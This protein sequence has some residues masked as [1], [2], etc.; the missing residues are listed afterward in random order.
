MRPICTGLATLCF[1]L[2]CAL[3]AACGDD[4]GATPDGAP[5]PVGLTLCG[6]TCV[7]T[8]VDG[9]NCGACGTTCD[10][11]SV[12][13]GAGT[14][15]LSCQSGLT[16]CNG[17]CVDTDSDR[18]NCGACGT[19]CDPG[20]VCDG[21]GQCALS[22]QSGLI[23]CNGTCIDP[24]TDRA[25][26]GATADCQGANAGTVC[27]AGEVCETGTC[28]LSCPGGQIACNGACIDP[29][30]DRTYCGASADCAGANAGTTCEDGFVCNGAG[31]CELSCQSGLVDCNG[32]CIDP[33]TDRTY[34]GAS[35]DC[36]GANAGTT[37]DSGF[38]CN[39]AG[40]CA[41]S[42]QSGLTDCSGTCVALDT[43]ENCGA[44]GNACGPTATCVSG[45]C[46][47][48]N[49]VTFAFTGAAQTFVV[50]NGVT[51]I[52]IEAWG[53]SGGSATNN[54]SL[55][56][57]NGGK[58]GL[59]GYATGTLAVTPGE[60]LQILV[61]GAGQP[62]PAGGFNGGGVGCN[63]S[64]TC[65]T[66][67]GASDVRRGG[68]TLA[69]RVLVAGGGGGAEWTCSGNRAGAGGGLV[70]EDGTG[71]DQ[72]SHGG[73]GGT[74][75]AGGAGG[76]GSSFPSG[77]PGALGVGGASNTSLHGGGGG[78]GYYGGGGGGNDG[79]GG[80]GSSFIGG[81]TAGATV[82][83]IN[84]GNGRVLISW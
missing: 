46:V 38:V 59:G 67:G 78:A 65:S 84:D 51:A 12:C 11:G 79:D 52:T 55:C 22:C 36:A 14:C 30:T 9:A 23:D 45:S 42:C 7:D 72:P 71:G 68:T 62:G 24:D 3:L 69:D 54:S 61:G 64:T 5:C 21:A 19:T 53:A 44:C 76:P 83:G 66:G 17:T 26:C 41:L 37:C 6:S 1:I 74:Q 73:L 63:D 70:G 39:G 25:Y 33:D 80:G 31:S 18:A 34:C 77:S 20:F 28:T 27:G 4:N 50:P 47:P 82:P 32:T 16:D 60:T 13:N 8:N 35:A 57:T 15:E 10:P 43:D 49:V 56:G 48:V 75:T 58:P 40:S 2:S 29:A 81:V